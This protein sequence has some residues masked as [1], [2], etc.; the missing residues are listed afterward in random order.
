MRVL[1]ITPFRHSVTKLS[2]S[3]NRLS[4]KTVIGSKPN[5]TS[6]SERKCYHCELECILYTAKEELY[7]P[8]K[9]KIRQNYVKDDRQMK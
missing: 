9:Y 8:N 7:I 4:I 5:S 3:T 2:V 6:I 1:N